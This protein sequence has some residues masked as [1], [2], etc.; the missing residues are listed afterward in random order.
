MKLKK[1]LKQQNSLTLNAL[2]FLTILFVS[3]CG[4]FQREPEPP[5]VVKTQPLKL[6]PPIVPSIDVLN[7][8]SIEWLV[9]TPENYNSVLARLRDNGEE[10]VLYAVTS[11]GYINIVSNSADMLKTIEQQKTVIGVYKRW[12]A[13]SDTYWD[14]I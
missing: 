13:N 11:T 9:V 2:G 6:Q 4:A 5:L 7:L 12:S 8:N 1:Q 10:L 3:G 14:G